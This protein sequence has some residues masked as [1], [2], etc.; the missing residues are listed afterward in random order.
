[1]FMSTV[2]HSGIRFT[3]SCGNLVPGK[4]TLPHPLSGLGLQAAEVVSSPTYT[5]PGSRLG[6]MRV[7]MQVVIQGTVHLAK[8]LSPGFESRYLVRHGDLHFLLVVESGRGR[9]LPEERVGPVS[10][11]PVTVVRQ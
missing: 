3:C 7:A 4:A 11:S 8:K 9:L 2:R 1:M 5:R 6:A 10:V